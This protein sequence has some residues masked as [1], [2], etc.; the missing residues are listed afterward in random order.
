MSK[1]NL[2]IECSKKKLEEISK[3]KKLFD[4]PDDMNDMPEQQYH[5]AVMHDAF[6]FI[7]H[8]ERLRHMFSGEI[9]AVNQW[10]VDIMIEKLKKLKESL[11]K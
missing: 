9:L 10:Q 1:I 4:L 7:D 11:P 3:H 5:N 6:F 2:D 8:N